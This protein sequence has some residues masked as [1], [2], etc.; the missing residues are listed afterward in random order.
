MVTAL[1][2]VAPLLV[3][4]GVGLLLLAYQEPAL[5]SQRVRAGVGMLVAAL[6]MTAAGIALDARSP[7]RVR[8]HPSGSGPT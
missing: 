1:W 3:A 6:V 2:F 4:A 7:D 5:R 8:P